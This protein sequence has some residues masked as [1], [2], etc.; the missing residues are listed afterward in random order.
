L[1]ELTSV[2]GQL[3]LYA[4][5]GNNPIMFVD[6]TGTEW[7]HWALGAVVVVS[8]AVLTIVT[9]GGFAAGMSA[10]MFASYGLATA[11]TATSILAFA[12]VAAGTTLAASAVV[13]GIDSATVFYSG[14]SLK[15]VA[16][17]FMQQGE[18]AL[19]AT[20]SAG[21]VGAFNGYVANSVYR[22]LHIQGTSKANNM[23]NRI[24]FIQKYLKVEK[25][26]HIMTDTV[27]CNLMLI[28]LDIGIIMAIAL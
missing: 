2:V 7:W 17:V 19:Y 5:C 3:N 15:D 12:T 26:L 8:L 6:P 9:A 13:A 27:E 22:S 4:Y 20:F 11:S 1:G 24:Q 21:L 10:L 28:I 16:D 14:G 25:M 18:G 23:K